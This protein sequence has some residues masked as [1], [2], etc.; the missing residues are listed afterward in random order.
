MPFGS[1]RWTTC[2]RTRSAS[3]PTDCTKP[4]ASRSRQ[5]TIE[6]HLPGTH[7]LGLDAA[8]RWN[9][10]NETSPAQIHNHIEGQLPAY[11]GIDVDPGGS[12]SL[13]WDFSRDAFFDKSEFAPTACKLQAVR[14]RDRHNTR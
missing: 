3:L 7:P 13:G 9:P 2:G 1:T 11:F 10:L 14:Q 5:S 4:P 12:S 6:A 8:D